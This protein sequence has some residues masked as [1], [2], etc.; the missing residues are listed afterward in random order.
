MK[1]ESVIRLRRTYSYIY[2]IITFKSLTLD[3]MKSKKLYQDINL[4]INFFRIFSSIIFLVILCFPLISGRQP[5]T[6]DALAYYPFNQNVMDYGGNNLHGFAYG[7]PIYVNDRLDFQKNAINL[8]GE[9]DYLSFPIGKYPVLAISVWLNPEKDA[10]SVIIFDYGQKKFSTEID[11]ITSATNPA[12]FVHVDIPG[13]FSFKS[14]SMLWFTEWHH[15]YVDSGN[16]LQGPRIFLDGYLSRQVY[17]KLPLKALT[18]LL[19]VGKT[20]DSMATGIKQYHGMIDDLRV[21]LRP[22]TGLEVLNEYI[23]NPIGISDR[24]RKKQFVICNN[25]RRELYINGHEL[26]VSG[27]EIYSLSGKLLYRS[28]Y[29]KLID[30]GP[31]SKGVLMVRLIDYDGHLLYAEKHLHY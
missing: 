4:N 23:K 19:I 8:D 6:V 16:G 15:L 21:Y 9:I 2:C 22:L 13:N 17:S 31:L 10:D 14:T 12:Y 30:L 11:A 7:E 3:G 24:A 29:K 5:L 25:T 1:N 27:I 26:L 20:S 28:A 18:D